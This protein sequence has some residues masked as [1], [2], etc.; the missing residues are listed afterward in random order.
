M[1]G[2]QTHYAFNVTNSLLQISLKPPY[3]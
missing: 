2:F 1:D 3:R